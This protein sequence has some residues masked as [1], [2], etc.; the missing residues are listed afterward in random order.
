VFQ[1]RQSKVVRIENLSVTDFVSEYLEQNRPLIIT[2]AMSSWPALARWNP[3]HFAK[4]FGSERVQI[5]GDLFKLTGIDSLS[6]YFEKYFDRDGHSTNR[7]GSTVPY[8]RWYCHLSADE[9]VPWAD[10]AFTRLANDWARPSFFPSNSFALPVCDPP[11]SI[12]PTHDWFPA[13]GLFISARG[14]R[15][16][17]HADPWCSDA[18]LCQIYG[19]KEF[20][21][22]HP[23]QGAHLASGDRTVDIEAP[24]LQDFPTFS[25]AELMVR[26]TLKPGECLF[27]P[28]G[29]YH[30]FDSATDSISLTWNFVHLSRLQPFLGYL[31]SGPQEAEIKQLSYAY[32]DSPGQHP[33]RSTGLAAA[34]KNAGIQ[35]KGEAPTP[36]TR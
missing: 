18:I 15:T 10:E 13:K 24:N 25:Q 30:H 35:S 9:R 19:N 8:V 17:L 26:D 32:F 31:S 36:S 7:A 28:A 2:Q 14:A 1:Q 16:R 27:V 5:Y 11:D 33:I 34:L 22:Y 4:E 21:M 12:D 3:A 23:S 20:V 6:N 29:W